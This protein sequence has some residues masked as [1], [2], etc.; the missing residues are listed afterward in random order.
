[1]KFA[2]RLFRPNEYGPRFFR[3]HSASDRI[4]WSQFPLNNEPQKACANNH[5]IYSTYIEVL[6]TWDKN[7]T[8][9]CSHHHCG[10]WS[11]KLM[12]ETITATTQKHIQSQAM[13]TGYG[14]NRQDFISTTRIWAHSIRL[15]G[16]HLP[17]CREREKNTQQ[18]C[19]FVLCAKLLGVRFFRQ[20]WRKC[21]C[22]E[23]N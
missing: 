13:L 21:I 12:V 2:I 1:M 9:V 7:L 11:G 8:M 22:I 19:F 18:S 17:I 5:N 20:Y 15:Y 14:Q 6:A 23:S 4:R 10:R 16:R 3:C